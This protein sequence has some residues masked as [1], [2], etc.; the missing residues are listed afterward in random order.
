M[1]GSDKSIKVVPIPYSLQLEIIFQKLMPLDEDNDIQMGSSRSIK[2]K[3][4]RESKKLPSSN[5]I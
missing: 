4:L 5:D 3:S 1:T 2:V